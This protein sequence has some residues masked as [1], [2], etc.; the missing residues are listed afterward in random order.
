MKTSVL[1]TAL[2]KP[3]LLCT[4]VLS[5]IGCKE[6]IAVIGKQAPEI[7]VFDLAGTQRSLNEGKGKTILL[8]FW[9]ETC[10]V[11]IAELKTF[12][13]L[14]QSYPQNN[15]HII[16]I[17]VDGDK[18]DTQALVK[19]RE[20]SLLVVKDQLK[21]TAERYQLVGTPTSFVID[22]EG[23][24]LYKFEGLIPAQDLHLFFKG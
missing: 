18:A 21:I 2:F 20:I 1:L 8:N 22:P 24:I 4:I 6:D 5:C 13:Q 17:N 14:L 9:S 7:A 23:K 12:E 11:C 3:L 19:K 16:A 10:G 15:L